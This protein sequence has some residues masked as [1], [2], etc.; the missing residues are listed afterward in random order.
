MRAAFLTYRS[1][2][3]SIT[4]IQGAANKRA[5]VRT[6]VNSNI[7]FT[8]FKY[9]ILRYTPGHWSIVTKCYGADV[10]SHLAACPP[11]QRFRKKT[12]LTIACFCATSFMLWIVQIMNLFIVQLL[13][14]PVA[15]S[16]LRPYALLSNLFSNMN[17]YS[18][19]SVNLFESFIQSTFPLIS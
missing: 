3:E 15:S 2:L 12:V 7:V 9:F 1:L 17:L 6:V 4:L 18:S 13:C 8:K 11:F 16:L 19:L 14:Y 5:I 10:K